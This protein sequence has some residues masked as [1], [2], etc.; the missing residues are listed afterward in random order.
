MNLELT[1]A[2]G[3]MVA[4]IVHRM[5]L[6][7]SRGVVKLVKDTLKLQGVQVELLGDEVADDVEH[8]QEYGF[9]NHAFKDAEA[10]FLSVGGSR[11]HG[12]VA[13]VTDRRYRPKS[14]GEGDVCL[15]TDK[16][17][18]VYLDRANDIVHIGA[19]SGAEFIAQAAKTK[20]ELDLVKTDL[21]NLKIALAAHVH[22]GVLPG[23]SSTA[24]SPGFAAWTPH[25]PGSVA[26]TKGKVT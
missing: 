16:G 17:E 6:T 7:V 12:I 25:T 10:L 18:R 11:A 4:P 26:A 22:P 21:D 1:R 9:T 8:F 24:V 20:S 15:F 23:P 19:K 5:R 3:R 14:L 2:I 13:C